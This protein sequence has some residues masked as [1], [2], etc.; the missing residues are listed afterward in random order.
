MLTA[1]LEELILD[2]TR[3]SIYVLPLLAPLAGSLERISVRG[4][5]EASNITEEGVRRANAAFT[6]LG[7][8]V[9]ITHR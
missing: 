5:V 8:A 6:Q 1:A 4:I 9:R 7:G 3:V 2:Q